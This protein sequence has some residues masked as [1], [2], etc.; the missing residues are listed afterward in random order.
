MQKIIAANDDILFG[1]VSVLVEKVVVG[2]LWWI[3]SS[4]FDDH[5]DKV[6]HSSPPPLLPPPF[7]ASTPLSSPHWEQ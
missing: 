6:T 4:I 3:D 7:V 2:V 5:I 1:G